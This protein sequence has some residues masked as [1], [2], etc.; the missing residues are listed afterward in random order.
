[1]SPAVPGLRDIH[2]PASPGWWPPA[3]GWWLLAALVVAALAWAT[4]R[5]LRVR[6]RARRLAA[7]LDEFDAALAR[8]GDIPARLATAS[9][10]LRRAARIHH[11]SASSLSGKD[12]LGF[13]DGSDPARPFSQGQGIL[14]VDGAFRRHLD[15]DVEP[16]L[17][18]ARQRFAA[19]LEGGHQ[20][21]GHA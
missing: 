2:L 3:P 6:R 11:P 5:F 10:W 15:V 16:V 4:L 18:L 19:L 21:H 9:E 14:L 1:M 7:A 17:A 20:G 12:W 8:A 13:L